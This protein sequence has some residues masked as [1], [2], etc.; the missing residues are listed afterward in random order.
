MTSN[1]VLYINYLDS[2]FPTQVVQWL[3]GASLFPPK[4]KGIRKDNLDFAFL[5]V[6][7][8]RETIRATFLDSNEFP[9]II[10]ANFVKRDLHLNAS[11]MIKR[12]ENMLTV[13]KEK[14]VRLILLN[15][16]FRFRKQQV[17][18]S[19]RSQKHWDVM[20]VS[21]RTKPVLTKDVMGVM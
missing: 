19:K 8:S 7:K 18:V 5:S 17:G 15:P 6:F 1:V 20:I 9:I 14:T 21:H 11:Q 16:K 12:N 10:A 2:A 13:A 4:K 3:L